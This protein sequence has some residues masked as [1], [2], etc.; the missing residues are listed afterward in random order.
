MCIIS[1]HEGKTRHIKIRFPKKTV[2]IL[3]WFVLFY[4]TNLANATYEFDILLVR[5]IKQARVRI[6]SAQPLIY[7]K[8]TL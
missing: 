7:H 6:L 1:Q 2:R 8:Q 4:T 5:T 3:D